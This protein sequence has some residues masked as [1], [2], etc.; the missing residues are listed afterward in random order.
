MC[1]QKVIKEKKHT[2]YLSYQE[3]N[4]YISYGDMEGNETSL[5]VC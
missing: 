2:K 3:N 5:A 4:L 1:I